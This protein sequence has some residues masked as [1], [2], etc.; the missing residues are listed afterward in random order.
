MNLKTLLGIIA[1]PSTQKRGND[2][3]DHGS[4]FSADA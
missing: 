3:D 2:V 4:L 1:A